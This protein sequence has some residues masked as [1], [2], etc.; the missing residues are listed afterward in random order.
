M[1]PTIKNSPL[2]IMV[3]LIG[4]ACIVASIL[5]MALNHNM[6]WPSYLL[7]GILILTSI[8]VIISNPISFSTVDEKEIN[9]APVHHNHNHREY[10][11]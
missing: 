4:I 9:M 5:T 3:V 7:L 6:E 8:V 2:T 11:D 1:K 10:E